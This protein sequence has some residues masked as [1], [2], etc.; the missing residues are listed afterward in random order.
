VHDLRRAEVEGDEQ[1]RIALLLW[2]RS[3]LGALSFTCRENSRPE[4]VVAASQH[5]WCA[6]VR[7]TGVRRS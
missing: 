4:R 1:P 3:V 5:L 7:T 6:T 2:V